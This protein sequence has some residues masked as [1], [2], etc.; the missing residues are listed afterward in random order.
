MYYKN[1]R[2]VWKF[3]F[4]KEIWRIFKNLKNIKFLIKRIFKFVRDS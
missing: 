1:L 4:F 3:N 2:T